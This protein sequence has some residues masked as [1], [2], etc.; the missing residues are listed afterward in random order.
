MNAHRRQAQK[1]DDRWYQRLKTPGGRFVK[2][3]PD[4]QVA[5]RL[6][7][8]KNDGKDSRRRSTEEQRCDVKVAEN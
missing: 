8:R 2:D 6:A 4:W 7:G 5:A 3:L 1:K